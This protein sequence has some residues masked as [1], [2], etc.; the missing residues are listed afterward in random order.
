MSVLALGCGSVLGGVED[1]WVVVGVGPGTEVA[2]GVGPGTEAA[3]GTG[4]DVDGPHCDGATIALATGGAESSRF[5]DAGRGVG[6]VVAVEA[7]GAL[8]RELSKRRS[9]ARAAAF[10]GADAP[11]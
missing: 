9:A 11:G 5:G 10:R 4:V 6:V 3:V 8:V 2:V 1:G 7:V